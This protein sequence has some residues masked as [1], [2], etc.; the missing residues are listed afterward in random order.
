M[1]AHS[2]TAQWEHCFLTAHSA[3]FPVRPSWYADAILHDLLI[4]W[5]MISKGQLSS[6]FRAACLAA[7]NMVFRTSLYWYLAQPQ[8]QKRWSCCED[9]KLNWEQDKHTISIGFKLQWNLGRNKQRCPALEISSSSIKIWFT[10][11]PWWL[12]RHT[13]QQSV[14]SKGQTGKHFAHIFETL[15]PHS[16]RT[17]LSPFTSSLSVIIFCMW[18]HIWM[19]GA[20]LG[21][22][23]SFCFCCFPPLLLFISKL[24]VHHLP[25]RHGQMTGQRWTVLGNLDVQHQISQSSF[26][27]N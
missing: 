6:T 25:V 11:S 19:A 16:S 26:D 3:A 8:Y 21:T 23:M 7:S 18:P 24:S 22:I 14:F 12:R 4:N 9:M 13:M 10:K 5:Q 1:Q 2:D 20:L 27:L 17:S 15:N